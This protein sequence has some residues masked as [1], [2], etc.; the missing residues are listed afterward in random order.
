MQGCGRKHTLGSLRIS[1][2]VTRSLSVLSKEDS[3]NL[4][5]ATVLDERDFRTDVETPFATLVN[6]DLTAE[7]ARRGAGCE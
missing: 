2:E 3:R 4:D 5:F 6:I 7:E 1:T